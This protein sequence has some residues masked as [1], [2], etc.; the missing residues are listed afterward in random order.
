MPDTLGWKRT[1][2]GNI[3][4]TVTP[5]DYGNLLFALG[6]AAGSAPELTMRWRIIRLLNHVN[7]G[8]PNYKPYDV[9]TD[10]T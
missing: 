7:E 5:N 8:N 1:E 2:D 4:V 6:L 10:L 9:P 3:T